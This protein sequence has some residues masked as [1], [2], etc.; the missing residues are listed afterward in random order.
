MIAKI[1]RKLATIALELIKDF[2]PSIQHAIIEKFLD[3]SILQNAVL[4]Y[5][6][7]VQSIKQN[8]ESCATWN[9]GSQVTW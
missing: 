8:Q 6:I 5:L 7:N 2:E 1:A 3:H 9:M 4:A